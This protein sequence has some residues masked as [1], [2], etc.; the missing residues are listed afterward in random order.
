MGGLAGGGVGGEA[1]GRGAARVGVGGI[2]WA[3]GEYGG[4]GGGGGGGIDSML[5]APGVVTDLVVLAAISGV[6]RVAFRKCQLAQPA[7]TSPDLDVQCHP[8]DIASV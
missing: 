2:A 8:N 6:N 4:G 7:A 1:G 5:T 3:G